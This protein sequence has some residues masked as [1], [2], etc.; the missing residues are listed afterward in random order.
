MLFVV[1]ERIRRY[2]SYYLAEYEVRRSLLTAA[3]GIVWLIALVEIPSGCRSGRCWQT[4][5]TREQ[6]AVVYNNPFR[7]PVFFLIQ[8]LNN[9][10]P[11]RVSRRE[12]V[13]RRLVFFR[14]FHG[15]PFVPRVR[16]GRVDSGR[17]KIFPNIRGTGRVESGVVRISHGSDR[18]W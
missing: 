10:P 13:K 12:N 16:Y 3:A 4:G 1:L 6:T 2:G 15:S 18:V 17:V 7:A 11:K 9:F 8:I 5:T 14:G